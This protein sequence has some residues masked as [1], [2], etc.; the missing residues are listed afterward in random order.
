MPAGDT[1]LD[2]KVT[3]ADIQTIEAN[4]GKTKAYW[5]NGDF[6]DSH[7]VSAQDLAMAEANLP[8]TPAAALSSHRTQRPRATGKVSTAATDTISSATFPACPCTRPLQRSNASTLVWNNNTTDPRGLLKADSNT[9]DNI[10][11]AWT[12]QSGSFTVDIGLPDGLSHVVTIYADDWNNLGRSEQVQVIDPST[13]TVLDTRTISSFSGGV[14]L[15]WQLTGNVELKFTGLNGSSPVLN[16]IFFD[17]VGS[18]LFVAANKGV[19]GNWQGIYGA[20]G[21]DL[22]G[23]ASD[24][25]SYA[26]VS[27]TNAISY[28]VGQQTQPTCAASRIP[29]SGVSSRVA[30]AMYSPTGSFTVNIDLTD[31][32]THQV[33]IYVSDWH[34]MV[35]RSGWNW[36][37]RPTARSSTRV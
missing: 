21:Y 9:T 12:S 24:L 10:A 22:F 2:G 37:T 23:Y 33:T 15:S 29:G 27:S 19:Q 26:Q 17:H 8:A 4:M 6:T 16:G 28:H 14:Y 20:Q 31:G 25:P 3:T 7:V 32:L 36:S 5:D 18:Q 11:A 35:D 30:S 13:G 1:N 34:N